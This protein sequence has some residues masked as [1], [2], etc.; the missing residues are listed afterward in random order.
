M[1]FHFCPTAAWDP[2]ATA[3]VPAGF[4][5]DGFIH[6]SDRG[7]VHLS[8]T[9]LHR[10]SRDLLLLAVDPAL[11][12]APL[13]WEPGDPADPAGAWFPHLYGPLPVHAVVRAGPWLPGD[14]GVFVPPSW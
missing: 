2:T 1:I 6:F 8:A 10:G 12:R 4:D 3:Y 5:A 13:R 7:T 11:V 9:A 14:D